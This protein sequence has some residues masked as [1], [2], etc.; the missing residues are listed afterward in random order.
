MAR[1]KTSKKL[2]IRAVSGCACLRFRKA[3]RRVSQI[4]DKHLEPYALTVTQYALLGHLRTY[5]GIGIGA[6][7]DALV[8]DPTTLT[9]N[10]RPL[11]R[12]NLVAQERDE[13]DRRSR[14]LHLTEAGIRVYIEARPGW[15]AAQRQITKALG[16]A[17][18]TTISATIDSMLERLADGAR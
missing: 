5:D 6:L 15:E 18:S 7:A 12:R 11:E 16:E 8:M 3:A 1:E 14:H 10:L 17:G 13:Q 4:Y 2:P 9:R